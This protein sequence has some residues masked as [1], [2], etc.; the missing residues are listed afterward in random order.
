MDRIVLGEII[1]AQNLPLPLT[2][3]SVEET[4]LPFCLVKKGEKILHTT[5]VAAVGSGINRNPIWTYRTRS[6]FLLSLSNEKSVNHIYTIEVHTKSSKDESSL[7]GYVEVE[8][9]ERNNPKNSLTNHHTS[10]LNG[11]RM[12]VPMVVVSPKGE[13]EEKDCDPKASLAFRFQIANSSDREVVE[14]LEKEAFSEL[15]NQFSSILIRRGKYS[16]STSLPLAQLITEEDETKIAQSTAWN[17]LTHAFEAPVHIDANTNTK[18]YRTK[19]Y[20]DPNNRSATEYLSRKQLEHETFQ[21]PSKSW[22]RCGSGNL[23]NVYVEVLGCHDL[24]NMDVGEAF[25]DFTDPFVCLVY[26]DAVAMTDVIDDSLSPRWPSWSQRAFCFGMIHPCSTLYVGVFDYD[27]G[28]NNDHDPVG[29]VAINLSNF[30]FNTEYTLRY[31]L[32]RSSNV[33]DRTP[34]GS[35]TI[36]VRI[37]ALSPLITATLKARENIHVNVRKQKTFRVVRYTCFGEYDNEESFDLTVVRSYINEILDYKL[38]LSYTIRD[39]LVSLMLWRGQ[40]DLFFVKNKEKA[41]ESRM[42]PLYS[43]LFF[44]MASHLVEAPYKIVPFTFFGTAIMMLANLTNRNQ[45]PSPW[46]QCPPLSHYI[47]AMSTIVAEHIGMDTPGS[48]ISNDGIVIKPFEADKEACAFE[49]AIQE[50]IQRDRALAAEKS[51]VRQAIRNYGDDTI[52]TGV[53][54]A[55]MI[56][57]VDIQERLTRYQG[58]LA[59]IAQKGRILCRIVNWEESIV[60][61]WITAA[62]VAGGLITL[63]LPW[64]FLFLWT[65]RIVIWGFFGPHMKLLDMFFF[66]SGNKPQADSKGKAGIK[67]EY[68]LFQ[69]ARLR[70]EEAAKMKDIREIAFGQYSVQVPSYNVSRHYDRPL[71]NSFATPSDLDQT[72][73]VKKWIPG[74]HLHGSMIPQPQEDIYLSKLNESEHGTER[75]G[76]AARDV[77][78]EAEKE[79]TDDSQ[80]EATGKT[81]EEE[82]IHE[83]GLEVVVGSILDCQILDSCVAIK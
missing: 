51:K 9:N 83:E 27:L 72:I 10:S 1:G 18:L 50:R 38:R 13:V 66:S 79:T 80:Q 16:Q 62:L 73:E 36:R 25:G 48:K 3:D 12:E 11:H 71:T 45:H 32:Y 20:P 14:L 24:P 15:E 60:S 40:V 70:R 57:P 53:T 76:F 6:Y 75:K 5:K 74:Q 49:K 68:N 28:V 7:L 23:G 34:N 41:E 82:E 31:N 78:N 8:L 46:H 77:K 64:R 58:Y 17:A 55:G 21:T 47:S 2:N 63:L 65:G 67:K 54:S 69:K 61:F 59:K 44:F 39:S 52:A 42:V 33:T 4:L 26:E 81:K 29:R 22:V 37:E 43:F 30:H 35:I 19:P 56:I